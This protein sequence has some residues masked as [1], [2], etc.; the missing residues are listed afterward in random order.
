MVQ[1]WICQGGLSSGSL[2]NQ[3]WPGL[4]KCEIFDRHLRV[5]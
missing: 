2:R 4:H 1:S 3:V 5:I